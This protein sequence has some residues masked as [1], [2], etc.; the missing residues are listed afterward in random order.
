MRSFKTLWVVSID[1]CPEYVTTTKEKAI[2]YA[3]KD[4][5]NKNFPK[6]QIEF[7]EEDLA[8]GIEDILN[9]KNYYVSYRVDKIIYS[10][11]E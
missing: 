8:I 7:A 9:I 3:I 6:K 4:M 10:E 2:D 5:K 11:G 1:T